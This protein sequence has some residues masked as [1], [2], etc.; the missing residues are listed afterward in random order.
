MSALAFTL[1]ALALVGPVP[2]VLARAAW[3]LRAP[4]AAIVLWQSIALAAV[5][6]AFSAG[7]AIASRLFVP[8]PDGRPTATITSEIEALGW[9]LWLL[10]VVV[11][12]LTL[13]I[14]GRLCV[15]VIQV[16]VATRRRRAHHR[17]MVDLLSKSRDAVPAHLCTAHR[18][19]GGDELRIL[20]VAQPLAYCL[21]G[22]RSRVVVSEG[23]LTTLSDNEVAAIL[24]HERAHLRARHDLV[25]EMFTAV[26]AAFPRF[27]RSA[28]ALD[29][30]RLLIELLADDAAVRT[31]GPTPLARALVACANGRTPS[32][33]LAAGGPTT[34]IRVRRLG[35]K[36]NS[37]AMAVTAYLA[38]A[39]VLVVPTVAVAVPWLTELHR[40]FAGLG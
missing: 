36:P 31:A 29:A 34:V 6:S 17:M 25:L 16:A 10:L 13:F 7:I 3:P 27:V 28:N 12:T 21:P 19:L 22:V 20:D 40:L 2:A 8:G 1:V 37:V 23:T 32:G 4:R 18:P 35:G 39:A 26:H 38:A 30:V 5:L 14:G 11:F 15:A 9:P 24:T 33:A